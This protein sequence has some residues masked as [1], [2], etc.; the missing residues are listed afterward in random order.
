MTR[1]ITLIPGDGVG[2]EIA[3][4]VKRCV[5]ALGVGIEWDVQQAGASV[6]ETEKE[7]LPRRV[8]DSIRRNRVALKGP[9]ETPVGGGFRSVNVELRQ[10]LDLYAC[11]RPCKYYEGI[12]SR[13]EGV[14]PRVPRIEVS[15]LGRRATVMGAI[16]LVV[17]ATDN[18]YVVRTLS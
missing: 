7:P 6:V 16:V 3:E 13:I 2:P 5:S 15:Q 12:R 9:V 1:T 8:L 18:Y 14:I 11:V 10:K 17:H 4:V